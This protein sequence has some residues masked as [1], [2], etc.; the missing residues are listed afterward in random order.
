[1][2]TFFFKEMEKRAIGLAGIA[3][4]AMMGSGLKSDIKE[5]AKKVQLEPLKQHEE[6]L[7]LPGS[8][9][10]D[11]EGGKRIDSTSITAMNKY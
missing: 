4:G 3:M 7:Q 2:N 8:N 10:Y 9:A 6:Q 11:F 5:N 1:M